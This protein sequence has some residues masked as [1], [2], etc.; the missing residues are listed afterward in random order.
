MEAGNAGNAGKII[1]RG[2]EAV[3]YIDEKDGSGSGV[4]V[5]DRISKSY[6]IREIDEK[7]RKQRTKKEAGL[8]KRA[9]CCGVGVPNASLSGDYIIKMDY[10]EGSRV[11]DALNAMKKAGQEEIAVG[12][13]EAV[14]ALHSAGIIHGDLTTS[15][16]ILKGGRIF[17]I[18][19]GLGK[20][21]QK[22]EDQATDLFLLS[23]ALKS[24]HFEISGMMWEKIINTYA[25]KYS[26]AREVMLRLEKI[27]KRRRYK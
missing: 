11:K 25:L 26:N 6:R 12:I 27:E 2:A 15:N 8:L 18:D 10:I 3:L 9:K 21:S 23:E 17:M 22:V 5:K 14:A 1:Q 19:F 16:M 20:L 7:I 13:G 24:T 4:L